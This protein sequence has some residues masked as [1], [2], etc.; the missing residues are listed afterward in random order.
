MFLPDAK[1]RI[2]IEISRFEQFR[3]I[4]KGINLNP[5]QPSTIVSASS[6]LDSALNC[7]KSFMIDSI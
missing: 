2:R 3:E 1:D 5:S 4:D 7:M 6:T